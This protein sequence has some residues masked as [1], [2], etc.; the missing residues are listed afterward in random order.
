MPLR[1]TGL[2]NLL[3]YRTP[4]RI[5]QKL[6]FFQ[7]YS[8]KNAKNARKSDKNGIFCTSQNEKTPNMNSQKLHFFHFL[9]EFPIHNKFPMK[10]STMFPDGDNVKSF[11]LLRSVM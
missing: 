9:V 2:K 11:L 5:S 10:I 7:I 3:K 8:G 1:L 4:N 6:H